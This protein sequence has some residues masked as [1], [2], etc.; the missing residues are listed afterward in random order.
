VKPKLI[1]VGS[2]AYPRKIDYE[3]L[4][5]IAHEN[6]AYLMADV[7]HFTG[8]IAAGL[9]PNPFPHAD[10][11]TGSTTKTLCGPH[12][13]FVMCRSSLAGAVEQSIYPG[14]VASLHLQTV[15]A[16]AYALGQAE[17]PEFAGLM[18]R[19]VKN[20]QHLCAALQERGFGIFTGGTDCHMFLADLR[21]FGV[22]G[23]TYA[24][25]LEEAGILVNSKAIPFDPSPV[26]MG[27]RAGTTVLTQQDLGPDE[28]ETI[29]DLY[30]AIAEAPYDARVLQ[31]VRTEAAELTEAIRLGAFRERVEQ[32]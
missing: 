3:R 30:L 10:L 20:A 5:R 14:H 26:P 2:A 8:L 21:P 17:T 15:A 1:V 9:S 18:G 29:A 25:R 12:S 7:A 24:R 11:V 22:D 27:I 31:Q 6:G 23:I 32:E 28:M 19:V 16:M 4:S 13:G